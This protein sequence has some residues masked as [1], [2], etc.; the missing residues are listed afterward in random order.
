MG[1]LDIFVTRNEFSEIMSDIMMEGYIIYPNKNVSVPHLD[2]YTSYSEFFEDFNSGVNA[3]LLK[4]DDFSRYPMK[5]RPI[6]KNG[7]D[8]WYPRSKE[9]GPFIEMYYFEPQ[10]GSNKILSASLLSVHDKIISPITDIQEPA[11]NN[12]KI[13]FLKIKEYIKNKFKQIKIKRH[14]AYISNEVVILLKNGW[15]LAAPFDKYVD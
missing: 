11:G 5:L 8:F 6:I 3:F 9:G 12:T 2:Q 15:R 10:A 7:Q 4:H 13:A 14:T 1:E